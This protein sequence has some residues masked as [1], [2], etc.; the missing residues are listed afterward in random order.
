MSLP[1]KMDGTSLNKDDIDQNQRQK[2]SA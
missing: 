1:E 2:L